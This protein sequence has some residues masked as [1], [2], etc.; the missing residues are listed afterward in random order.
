MWWQMSNSTALL[1]CPIFRLMKKAIA[2]ITEEDCISHISQLWQEH[3]CEKTAW[4]EVTQCITI[5]LRDKSDDW[6]NKWQ[7]EW[8]QWQPIYCSIILTVLVCVNQDILHHHSLESKKARLCIF[9]LNCLFNITRSHPQNTV[10]ACM[11]TCDS[12][13]CSCSPVSNNAFIHHHRLY[14][15]LNSGCL[16]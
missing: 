13:L 3:F 16:V 11:N 1:D 14:M 2:S 6:Q 12:H 10:I 7:G 9:A 15:S 5:N 4:D 8:R